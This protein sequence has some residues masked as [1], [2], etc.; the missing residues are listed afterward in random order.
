MFISYKN[1][2]VHINSI[3]IYILFMLIALFSTVQLACT[4]NTNQQNAASSFLRHIRKNMWGPYTVNYVF[5]CYQTAADCV[6]IKTQ[7][8]PRKQTDS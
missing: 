3:F 2:T 5:F 4:V 1:C 6:L 7:P 8:Q